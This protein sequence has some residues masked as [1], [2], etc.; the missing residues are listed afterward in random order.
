M[1]FNKK[2]NVYFVGIGGISMSAI[3]I[4]LKNKGFTVSGSDFKESEEVEEL[5]K[6]GIKVN[7]GHKK[8]NI[9]SD[10]DLVVYSKAIHNDNEE[11][12]EAKAQ[13]IPLISRSKILGEIMA[14]Y[15]KRICVSGTHGKTTTTSIISKVLIDKKFDPTINIGGNVDCIG[16][17][18]RIGNNEDFFVAEACEYT[19]SFLDFYPN[20]AIVTNIDADHLDL[21]KD[22]DDIRNSF[23]K[24]VSLVPENGVVS[25]N[26]SIENYEDIVKDVK[27][28][29]VTFGDNEN[30][31][32][33]FK[34]LEYD[35]ENN[36]SFDVYKKCQHLGNIKQKLIGKHNA[37]NFI[38]AFSILD[39]LGVSFNDIKNSLADFKGAKRRLEVKGLV[40][41][42][43]FIDDYAHHPTE[44]LA[45]INALKNLSYNNMYLV[46]QPHTYSR[47]KALIDD[48]AY[49]LGESEIVIL[50]KIYAA[51]EN[52]LNEINSEHLKNKISSNKM[53]KNNFCEY[54]GTFEEIYEYIS[55]NA[56]NNDIVV[57]MGAG[58]I[59]KLFDLFID[60]KNKS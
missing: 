44:I 16:G 25:I 10:I 9:T 36:L 5:R 37:L 30:A 35:D 60:N 57:T 59:Y 38:A 29:V 20:Y 21:F 49:A 52:D 17:N 45:S 31:D 11:I 47:T 23:K 14:N 22:L 50:A 18:Y 54:F 40:N 48:F 46:F 56:K 6:K 43:T 33:Y 51:R 55:N 41:G 1:D 32:Y 39:N 24:F 53:N 7:I 13:N 19:N 34:N 27:A 58:D 2:Q 3:A 42:I 28:K 4:L 15:D 26:N 12:K 8:E